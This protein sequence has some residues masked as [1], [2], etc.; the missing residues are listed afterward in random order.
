MA[1]GIR[2]VNELHAIKELWLNSRHNLLAINS[3][4]S[5]RVRERSRSEGLLNS[6]AIVSALQPEVGLLRGYETS[7]IGRR[8]SDFMFCIFCS[9]KD[10][11]NLDSKYSAASFSTGSVISVVHLIH[12]KKSSERCTCH[13]VIKIITWIYS[14]GI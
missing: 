6:W 13:H 11:Q 14:L 7:C 2:T 10:N 1:V 5:V 4:P 9:V 8:N 12:I 3:L